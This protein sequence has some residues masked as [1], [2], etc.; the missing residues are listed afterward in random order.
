VK[1][2]LE[3]AQVSWKT[4]PMS[5]LAQADSFPWIVGAL[6][7]VAAI[8]AGVALTG[9]TENSTPVA[10]AT[11]SPLA[12][13][14]PAVSAAAAAIPAHPTTPVATKSPPLPAGQVWQ[15]VVNGQR[16]FSDAPCGT[17]ASIRQL[18]AV[19]GMEAAPREPMYRY[20]AY[21]SSAG[22]AAR[23][24]GTRCTD[25]RSLQL[26]STSGARRATAA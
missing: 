14:H 26:Q 1:P 6:L 2:S 12:A 15:C 23:R 13:P 20:P 7:I 9:T 25:R 10:V 4:H 11:T 24:S 8:P 16:T 5:K 18:N 19:N 21:D 17:G 22:Y 3:N